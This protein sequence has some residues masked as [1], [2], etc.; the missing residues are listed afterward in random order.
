MALKMK[1]ICP[2]QDFRNENA[3]N[4]PFFTLDEAAAVASG[5]SPC[6]THWRNNK[7]FR[8]RTKDLCDEMDHWQ[9]VLHREVAS[10]RLESIDNH[11][12]PKKRLIQRQAL[13]LWLAEREP[14]E[15]SGEGGSN[16]PDSQVTQRAKAIAEM[17]KALRY[18][19]KAITIKQKTS[20]RKIA[21]E[22]SPTLYFTPTTF[23]KAWVEGGRLGLWAIKN[24][25]KYLPRGEPP[26]KT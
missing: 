18:D 22:H 4:Y 7:E 1:C 16:N 11:L 24:K 17:I 23:D 14:N 19:P 20:L 6:C 25:K 15:A 5:Y 3:S 12:E 10:G 26:Q 21:R 13:E 8:D 2:Y 9:Q